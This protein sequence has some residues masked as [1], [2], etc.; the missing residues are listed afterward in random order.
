M[1]NPDEAKIEMAGGD[2]VR[3]ALNQQDDAPVV[4]TIALERVPN[5]WPWDALEIARGVAAGLVTSACK[6]NGG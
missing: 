2:S 1:P 3:V 4:I 5:G 6:M